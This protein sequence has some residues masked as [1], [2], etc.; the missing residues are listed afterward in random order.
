ML[1][2]LSFYIESCVRGSHL[3]CRLCIVHQWKQ[4]GVGWLEL[5]DD[6]SLL[7]HSFKQGDSAAIT[8]YKRLCGPSGKGLRIEENDSEQTAMMK[9]TAVV[10]MRMKMAVSVSTRLLVIPVKGA[11]GILWA[12]SYLY[13]ICCITCIV[14]PVKLLQYFTLKQSFSSK[15]IQPT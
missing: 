8:S 6:E 7:Y 2:V 11:M 10:M 12:F 3:L 5:T 14:V 15:W 9:I 13:L 4:V 1:E